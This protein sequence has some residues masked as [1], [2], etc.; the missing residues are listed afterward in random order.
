MS[1]SQFSIIEHNLAVAKFLS[2]TPGTKLP[3]QKNPK[4]K[5]VHVASKH[6]NTNWNNYR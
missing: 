1:N 2:V 6:W 4:V 3:P 5:N